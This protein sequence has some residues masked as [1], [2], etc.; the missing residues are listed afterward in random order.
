MFDIRS[1]IDFYEMLVDDFDDFMKEQHSAR[2]AFHCIL[3]AYHLRE[4]VWHDWIQNDENVRVALGIKTERE[5][6]KLVNDSCIWFPYFRTLTNGTKHYEPDNDQSFEA[7]KVVAMP[8]ALDDPNA[9]L[10]AGAWDGP[11]RY[12][13]GSLPVGPQGKGYLILDLGEGAGASR[14]IY[15]THVVEAVLR[16]WR[17]F[18]RRFKPNAAIRHSHHHVD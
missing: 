12:V 17:D 15:T 7:F 4:W 2:R 8:F 6:N 5:F 10:D 11:I 14:W 9:G 1:H 3:E 16:F 18:Y 13:S